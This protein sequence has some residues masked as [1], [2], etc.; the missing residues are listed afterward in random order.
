MNNLSQEKQIDAVLLRKKKK[1]LK[2]ERANS[3]VRKILKIVK[4]LLPLGALVYVLL[5]SPLFVISELETNDLS[6]IGSEE[7]ISEFEGLKGKNFFLT[8]LSYIRGEV[9]K[10]Y[11]FIERVYTEKIFP[12]KILINIREKEPAFV[13]SNDIGCFLLDSDGFVLLEGD[14]NFLKSNY[15]VKEVFGKDLNNIEFVPNTQSSFYNAKYLYEILNVMEYYGYRVKIIEFEN[16]MA[17]LELHDS[18]LFTFSFLDDI[19][20]QLKRLIIITKK[21]QAEEMPFKSIDLRY[22]RPVLIEQ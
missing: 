6:Y 19:D 5:Y 9:I 18:R 11:A 15:S 10:K 22:Q 1:S 12:N 7:I 20:V 8:D 17:E 4:I 14:C 13:V 3:F 16:H 21:T 2:K